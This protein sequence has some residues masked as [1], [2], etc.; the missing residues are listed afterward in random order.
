MDYS[1][2]T[3]EIQ[4]SPSL[5]RTLTLPALSAT[6]HRDAPTRPLPREPCA[7][8]QRKGYTE[9]R[10]RV[11]TLFLA[12]CMSMP[13]QACV[14]TAPDAA[15]CATPATAVGITRAFIAWQRQSP[16]SR[17][18]QAV[19]DITRSTGGS[20]SHRRGIQALAI[21]R[22]CAGLPM[23]AA[24]VARLTA[25]VD[26]TG[27]F[28][29][30]FRT[31]SRSTRSTTGTCLSSICWSNSR[32][33]LGLPACAARVARRM[34]APVRVGVRCSTFANA[35]SGITRRR[36]RAAM[37]RLIVDGRKKESSAAR[38]PGWTL[39]GFGPIESLL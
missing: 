4:Q 8:E 39:K 9:Q 12:Q 16:F 21:L 1:R 20:L 29:F 33:M 28:F 18:P 31:A 19:S 14:P 30:N 36:R 13:T 25:D 2:P 27:V 23:A 37:E 6:S 35:A 38:W 7:Q 3:S 24:C 10:E 17:P 5:Y 11:H 15:S 22:R 26:R 32:R 34:D